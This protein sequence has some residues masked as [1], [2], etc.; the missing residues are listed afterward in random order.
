MRQPKLTKRWL[1]RQELALQVVRQHRQLALH[2]VLHRLVQHELA[3]WVSLHRILQLELLA[4]EVAL[5]LQVV[6]AL[7]LVASWAM[8]DVVAGP[9]M[10]D[11]L[12]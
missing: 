4:H 8:L 1:Q 3:L 11:D 5:A 10:L 9:T 7:Q 6:L 12:T 2:V